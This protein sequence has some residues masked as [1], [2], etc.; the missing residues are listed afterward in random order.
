MQ[1]EKI[2]YLLLSNFKSKK[3]RKSFKK[4]PNNYVHT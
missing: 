4:N 1:R 2:N 3:K